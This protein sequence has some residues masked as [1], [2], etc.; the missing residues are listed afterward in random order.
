M[1]I[2]GG[3]TTKESGGDMIIC[4]YVCMYTSGGLAHT[5]VCMYLCMYVCT[6]VHKRG[7]YHQRIRGGNALHIHQTAVRRDQACEALHELSV[8]V[9]MYVCIYIYIYIYVCMQPYALHIH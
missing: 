6:H 8:C 9:C 2:R 5:Y 3:L 1:Y 4:M 7:T